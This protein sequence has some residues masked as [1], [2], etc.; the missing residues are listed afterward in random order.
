MI[1]I[2]GAGLAGLSAAYHLEKPYTL[3]EQENTVGGLCR[4]I[5]LD[6]YV[7]DYAPHILFT[8]NPY[9]SK[10]FHDLSRQ[11]STH[12]QKKSRKNA[13]KAS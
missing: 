9:T 1:T 12:Y 5:D 8:R 2:V 11:T 4:S 7:F 13:Y 3:L 10:L 6:G